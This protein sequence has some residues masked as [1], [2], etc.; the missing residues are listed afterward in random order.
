M[1]CSKCVLQ[2]GTANYKLHVLTLSDLSVESQGRQG[3]IY[4]TKHVIDPRSEEKRKS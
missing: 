4:R 1:S 2:S 3:N